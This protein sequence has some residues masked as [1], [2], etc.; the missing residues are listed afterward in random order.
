MIP[1]LYR[2]L[3][4]AGGPAIALY[5]AW[6]RARGKED[7]A[8]FAE[9]LGEGQGGRPHGPLVWLH[10]ASVGEAISALPLIERLLARDAALSLLMTTG[11]VS[12]ARL[13]AERLPP[14]AFHRYVPIDRPQPVR[15]FLDHWRPDLALWLESELW[16]NLVLE[17][18]GRGV[19]M[20]L[21]N[22]RMSDRSFA[23]WRRW[24][25]LIRP[26]LRS[27]ALLLAQGEG[28]A[29]RFRALGAKSVAVTGTLKYDAAALPADEAE[30]ARLRAA[31]GGRPV[32]LAASTHEGEEEIAAAAHRALAARFPRLLTIVVPRH[33]PRGAAIAAL[34]AKQG[35]AAARRSAG[36]TIGPE[37]E[38]Y[39]ADSMGEL[40][41][42]Y[43]LAPVVFMGGSLVPHGGQNLLEPARLGCAILHGPHMGNFAEIAEALAAA[44]A[45]KRVADMVSLAAALAELLADERLRATRGEAARKV[46]E[47]GRGVLD[48]VMAALDPWLARLAAQSAQPA[49]ARIAHA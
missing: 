38:I 27:F 26:L 29:Q 49:E 48:C 9:R 36:E 23:G 20:I 14:R 3:T 22:G 4:V 31:L 30:L 16:P 39:L 13:A 33:P 19:P 46:A 45:A 24:P 17:T 25:G 34:L 6:R 40:G 43:R 21:V 11:T 37:T 5:L 8:R 35:F 2:A 15:R 10:A 32:W 28:D 12:S 41:L 44:G 47:A 42:F 18:H 1:A 7:A